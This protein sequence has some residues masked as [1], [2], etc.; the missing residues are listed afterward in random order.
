MNSAKPVPIKQAGELG[1]LLRYWRDARGKSQ[2]DLSL[3]SG[4]LQRHLSFIESG[5]SAPGRQALLDIAQALDIPLRERKTLLLSAGYAP[6]YSENDWSAP[7]MQSITRELERALQQHDP[8]PAV[9]MDRYW[10]VLMRNE[11]AP[12]FFNQFIDLEAR[13]TPRNLLHLMFD[14]KGMRPFI[15]NWPDVAASLIQRV[16]RESIG[17][18]IDE[19]TKELLAQLRTYP[20]VKAEWKTP[21]SAGALPALA[22][23]GGCSQS[24]SISAHPL[25]GTLATLVHPGQQSE[26]LTPIYSDRH[27]RLKQCVDVAL[28]VVKRTIVT[29]S[30]TVQIWGDPSSKNQTLLVFG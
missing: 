25:S 12:H 5:R 15:I 23:I 22:L 26:R 20:G 16:Y 18:I 9:V 30:Q 3:D 29:L 1:E 7:E 8:F 10:Y 14:P 28:C 21:Q 11:S 2:L 27:G 13:K 4:F 19:K 24:V 17:R 6:I